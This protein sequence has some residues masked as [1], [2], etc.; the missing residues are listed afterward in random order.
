M[1]RG[2]E[3][4][5]AAV[6]ALLFLAT[7][8]TGQWLEA[9]IQ[10]PAGSNPVALCYDS[11]DNRIY[12]ACDST[13]CVVVID[14]VTD[15]V[16]GVVP[17]PGSPQDICYNPVDNKVYCS[18]R[19]SHSLTIIDARAD[20]VLRTVPIYDYSGVLCYNPANDRVY[21]AYKQGPY[22]QG[23]E[24]Y[25]GRTNGEV[26]RVTS[27]YFPGWLCCNAT[28]NKVYA[29]SGLSWDPY[30]AVI[31]GQNNQVVLVGI[32]Q[33][34]SA[35]GYNASEDK[36]YCGCRSD[37]SLSVL[38][39]E[40]NGLI[41]TA[42]V[43]NYPSAICVNSRENRVYTAN[44]VANN[45][46]VLDGATD[47]VIATVP[48]GS[49]PDLLCYSLT[50]SKVYCANSLGASVTVIDGVTSSVVATIGVGTKPRAL[51][52]NPVQNRVYVANW[53]DATISVI[54]DSIPSGVEDIAN[55]ELRTPNA[56]ATVLSG[57]A[58]LR[59]DAAS[60]VYDAQG[61]QVREPGPGVYFLKEKVAGSSEQYRMRKVIITR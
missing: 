25:D 50:N 18:N 8:A 28:R 38:D 5:T 53:A 31:D 4:K 15:S 22:S 29:A 11:H 48:V 32:G 46:S 21:I 58:G 13:D 56:G 43:R 3:M 59:V 39:G 34:I 61:R 14:G 60:V 57:V 44:N 24:E 45:V 37:S 52:W 23:V 47:S 49:S 55:G 33:Y 27:L 26:A 30:L 17:S 7:L 54:R 19:L 6:L 41:G 42:T 51:A 20:T 9:T 35:L 36:V 2:E 16:I 12:C 1:V 10:L 40:T